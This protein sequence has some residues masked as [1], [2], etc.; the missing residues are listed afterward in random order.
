MKKNK[1]SAN[2]NDTASAVDIAPSVLA[3]LANQLKLDLSKP[4]PAS[5]PSHS[6]NREKKIKERKESQAISLAATSTTN[7]VTVKS[8]ND[9]SASVK[10]KKSPGGK[11]KIGNSLDPE[12]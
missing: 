2:G 5:K 7:N 4:N 3:N 11:G 10:P 8:K 9:F 1:S 12:K 6:S